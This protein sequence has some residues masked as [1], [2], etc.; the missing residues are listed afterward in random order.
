VSWLSSLE[1]GKSGSGPRGRGVEVRVI[2]LGAEGMNRDGTRVIVSIPGLGDLPGI[3]R[4]IVLGVDEVLLDVEL[5]LPGGFDKMYCI[6]CSRHM[7]SMDATVRCVGPEAWQ[8]AVAS[9]MRPPC[10]LGPG[11]MGNQEPDTLP[12]PPTEQAVEWTLP[13]EPRVPMFD[14]VEPEGWREA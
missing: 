3:S 2:E 4:D 9:T 8:S 10:T 1:V 13:P 5:L 6:L 11:R 12:C 14:H 7:R